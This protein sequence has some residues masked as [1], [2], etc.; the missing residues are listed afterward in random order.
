MHF[1]VVSFAAHEDAIRYIRHTVFT[2]EQGVDTALDFDGLDD[3][4]IQVLCT[5]QGLPVGTGRMLNDGHIGRVAVLREC[6]DKGVG[7]GLIKTLIETARARRFWEVYLYA[8]VTAVPFYE[9]LGFE[10]TGDNFTEAG[11][12]HTPMSLGLRP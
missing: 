4:A 10:A 11:I 5:D 12:L 3:K 7:A 1:D 9:K 6:R 2:V 8:Q